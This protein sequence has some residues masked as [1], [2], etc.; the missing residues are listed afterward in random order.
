MSMSAGGKMDSLRI[1]FQLSLADFRERT[2]RYSFLVTMIGVMFFGYLVITGQYTIQF[3][4][5]KSVYNSAWAGSLMAVCSTIM[6]TI[7]GF[8][9]VRGSI[10]R[11]RL[12]EVG[13]IIA[14]T[15][16]SGRVYIASKLASNIAALW[17]MVASL[18]VLAFITLLIR[19]DTGEISLWAFIKPFIIISLPASIFVASA[20]VLFDT[21]RWLR[22]SAGNIIYLFLAESCVLLGML[23]VPFLDLAS[24]AVFTDSARAAAGRAFPGETIGLLMGFVGFDPEMHFDLIKTF[25]WTGIEWTIGMLLL[26]LHWIAMAFM[27]TGITIL[28]FDRFDPAKDRYKRIRSN[29]KEAVS[30]NGRGPNQNDTGPGYDSLC[31]PE[32]KFRLIR[33]VNAELRLALKGFHWFWYAVAVGLVAAQCAAP[34]NIARLYLVPASMVWPLMIWSS[35]GTRESRFGTVQLLVSS[36]RPV[37]RQFTAIWLSGLLIAVASAAGMI[38]RAGIEGQWSYAATL[39]VAAFLVPTVSLAMGTLSGSRRL[40]EVTYLMVWYVGSIDH[41]TTLDLLGTIDESVYITKLAVLSLVVVG[42]LAI[43]FITRHRQLCYR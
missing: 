35:M 7:I 13:Q 6:M 42:S 21:V 29:Q 24:V 14:A 28:R 39:T 2:R 19:N 10:K 4:E 12:T 38:F 34:F 26:R 37:M 30:G 40:F 27:V 31:L 25:P 18:A 32:R 8:Y 36:P 1:L 5:Y 23:A 9:L 33:M 15:Q 11:D 17:S 20:A 16:M 3:G 43:A 41:L 22:G